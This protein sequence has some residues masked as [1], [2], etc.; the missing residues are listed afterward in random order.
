VSILSEAKSPLEYEGFKVY[1]IYK[2]K[3]LSFKFNATRH[4]SGTLKA[5]LKL[6]LKDYLQSKSNTNIDAE[7]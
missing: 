2:N 4:T 1:I 3:K 5:K 7:L 6:L